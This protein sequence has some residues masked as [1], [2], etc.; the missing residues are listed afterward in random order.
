VVLLK[1]LAGL[2]VTQGLKQAEVARVLGITQGAISLWERGEGKPTVDKISPLA[3]LYGVTVQEIIE[4]CMS[5]P[6][7]TIITEKEVLDNDGTMR[8]HLQ[9]VQG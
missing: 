9:N 1:K 8:E 6:H 3:E 2:R 4:A 5:S 7:T